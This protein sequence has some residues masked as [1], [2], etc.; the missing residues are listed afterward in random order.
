MKAI[1][2]FKESVHD[3]EAGSLM[4]LGAELKPE[5]GALQRVARRVGVSP[6]ALT[7]AQAA[8]VK[9]AAEVGSAAMSTSTTA[10]GTGAGSVFA[11]SVVKGVAIGLCMSGVAYLGVHLPKASTSPTLAPAKAPVV[12]ASAQ[13]VGAASR[14]TSSAPDQGVRVSLRRDAS[15]A[16]AHPVGSRGPDPVRGAT[17]VSGVALGAP[18]VDPAPT[19]AARAEES[20]PPEP[21]ALGG[22]TVGA[23]SAAGALAAGPSASARAAEPRVMQEVVSLDR[24]RALAKRGNATSAL[25]E[26][27]EFERVFGYR[28]LLGESMLVRIDVLLSLGKRE[29][30]A[31]IARRLLAAGAP[32]PQRQRLTVLAN[33]VATTESPAPTLE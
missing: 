32:A 25:R 27:D 24:V 4:A 21:P 23:S 28:V 9:A 15:T 11:L 20:P 7:A 3:I 18:G 13:V 6:A 33:S 14:L 10:L 5:P 16:Q 1:T 26:L 2:R 19:T 30:A 29:A 22:P 31:V 8:A 17:T 12:D